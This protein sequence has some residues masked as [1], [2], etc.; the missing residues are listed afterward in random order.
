MPSS[1]VSLTHRDHSPSRPQGEGWG[2]CR[3]AGVAKRLGDERM[4]CHDPN[5]HLREPPPT[6]E[7][8]PRV[9]EDARLGF[10]L[11][12]AGGG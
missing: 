6:A 8:A 12:R 2:R 7:L 4:H 10:T 9:P 3:V 1:S 11:Y 5:T